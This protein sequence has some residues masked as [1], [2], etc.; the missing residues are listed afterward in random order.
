MMEP[1]MYSVIT[2]QN[3][4]VYEADDECLLLHHLNL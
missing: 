3:N 1:M 2:L 4:V